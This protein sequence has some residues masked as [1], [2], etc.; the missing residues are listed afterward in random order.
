MPGRHTRDGA[1]GRRSVTAGPLV[2]LLTLAA[3]LVATQVA[4]VPLRDPDGVASRRLVFVVGLVL[5]L[6]ALDVV[7][8]AS[9]RSA[10]RR[11]TRAAMRAVLRQRWSWN[12][13]V[14]VGVALVSFY[15]TYLGYR[16]IKSVV[17]LLRP[18]DLFDD[19]LAELDRVLFAGHD[20]FT[21]LHSLLGTGPQSHFLSLVYLFFLVFVPLSLAC[22]LVFSRNLRGGLFFTT[23]LSINWP[24]G[25]A[26]YVLL[27]ALGPVYATPVAFAHLPGS[28]ASDLQNA[29]LD[30]RITFLHNPQVDGA[31]QA[32]AAFPS[33]H[34]SI[35]FTVAVAA[36]LL[37]L[38]RNV[39]IALWALLV[40]SS[41]ST[42]YLGWHYVVDGIAGV[43][44]G[45]AALA[46]A[47]L[48]TGFVVHTTSRRRPGPIHASTGARP[49]RATHQAPVTH[50]DREGPTASRTS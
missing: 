46:V 20:P 18:G 42:I 30:E 43:A 48:L 11:P 28:H 17:P 33:L 1:I 14:V 34:I 8:R 5:G 2:A 6:V 39:R 41:A 29:L 49:G 26:G 21:L 44:I 23:A 45:L 50:G 9:L 32:I 19:E 24:L 7:V 3:A 15:V 10:T 37:G 12:R 22:A 16:N 36:H 38:A 40:A 47:R 31:A 13:S 25:A 35:L 4:D 27:P